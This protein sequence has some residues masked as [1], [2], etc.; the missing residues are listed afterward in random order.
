M[1]TPSSVFT[2]MVTTT[3][4][5]HK[6]EIA[7]NVSNNNA[8]LGK[9]KSKG[10]MKTTDGG[11]EIAV[12]LEYAENSTYQRYSAFDQLNIQ[13]SDV[14]TAAKFAWKQT[15]VH[16]VASGLEL[17]NN[18]GKNKM[19]DLAKAK[20]NNA[21]RTFRN[22]LSQDIYSD[23]SLTNQIAGI[24]SFITDA[25]TGT[26]GAIDSTAFP[27]WKSIVQSAAAPIQG[28][29]A[30][31]PS[32]ATIKSLMN[33]L[34]LELVRGGDKPDLIASSN[35]YY[36]FYLESLQDNQRYQKKDSA[37]A[38]F[39]ALAFM[40]PGTEVIFDG[41]V[42]GGGIPNSRMYFLNTDFIEYKAHKD[43]NMTVLSEKVSV[44][45]DAVVIPIISQANMTVSN[46]SQ[47]GVLKP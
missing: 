39:G 5:D 43:A 33:A 44:N 32:K 23:G 3:L 6:K 30:I 12:P 34:M 21:M 4:R 17:R 20:I 38:G 13:P 37:M 41:G 16:I 7:D 36:T 22:G 2:G 26:V 28:G 42:Q 31:T 25:G 29:G 35:N 45:Q 46:R 9:L 10:R 11:Y 1:A 47:Q 18:S 15:A 40:F 24:Q 19:I 8:L 14:I 27:F